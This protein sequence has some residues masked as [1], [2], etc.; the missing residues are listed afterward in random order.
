MDH[1]VHVV[2]MGTR[3]IPARYGGFETAVE[4][5][6]A[7]LVERGHHVTV[8]CRGEGE[9]TYRGMHRVE[10]PALRRKALETIS[11]TAA[12]T[13]H[14]VFRTRP[15]AALVFNA[16]NAPFV[17]VMRALGIPVCLHLDGHDARRA[18]WRGAGSAYYRAATRWG[19]R[20]ANEVV[21]D[22]QAVRDELA[23]DY[24]LAARYIA[25][26]TPD[27]RVPVNRVGD[28]L[29]G[30]GF[31]EGAYHLVVARFEPENHVL[32]I[33]RGYTASS[34]ELPLVA[35]GFEGYPSGYSKA[36]AK[37]AAR[38]PRVRLL[39]AVWDQALLDALY[40][41]ACTYIHGHS[42]GGTN[43]SL[44]RA[45]AQQT[46]VIAFDCPYNRETTGGAAM[47]FT[48][49][50]GLADLV[51]VAEHDDTALGF[52]AA[53]LHDRARRYYRWSDVADAYEDIVLELAGQ[54]R[55]RH[56]V[57]NGSV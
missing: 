3:G 30:L 12:A 10:L 8:Y 2:L 19:S 17:P 32:D 29:A 53:R 50:E 55:S 7:R 56:R 23:A 40:A 26:G 24:G 37:E 48:G 36:I 39:G 57:G 1:G 52:L 44:L 49:A 18:K 15:H 34:A 22:S 21:V 9:P 45:M 43:P 38:D 47:W 46:P 31:T 5:I 51:K 27:S 20:L 13:V 11:H 41:G 35:V 16:A 54:P 33:I 4:E 6:G 14:A 42:V 25:Y 28:L